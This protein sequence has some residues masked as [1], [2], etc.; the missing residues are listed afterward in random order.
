MKMKIK[1]LCLILA[2]AGLAACDNSSAKARKIE[3]ES[4]TYV[5]AMN[6][7]RAGRMEQAIKGFRKVIKEEPHNTSARFQ[8]AYLLQESKKNYLE[9]VW[10]YLEYLSQSANSDKAKHAKDRLEMCERELAKELAVKYGLLGKDTSKEE[11]QKAQTELD[12]LKGQFADVERN[13]EKSR[14]EVEHLKSENARLVKIIKS[15]GEKLGLE[16]VD[17]SGIKEAKALLDAENTRDNGKAMVDGA[18]T[19]AEERTEG[20]DRIKASQ[21]I[22]ALKLEEK[23]E[24]E[25]ASTILPVQDKD[26][27]AKREAAEKAKAE[28]A[29]KVKQAEAARPKTYVV[30][31]GDTLYKIAIKFY[32]RT[33]AWR[34]IQNAN[35]TAISMD[36]RVKAGQKIVLP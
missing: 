15:D 28:A 18:K 7:Y 32:N 10:C 34:E 30:Q 1:S 21:D 16:K 11:L 6:D 17:V 22:A 23:E 33:S 26:A 24:R 31:E 27:K 12:N 3:R 20:I 2:M 4:R 14:I 19:G 5:M 36:G 35:K 8:L 29:A 25:L 9:A 13:L